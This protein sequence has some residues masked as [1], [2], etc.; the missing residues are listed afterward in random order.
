MANK[1][2]RF[3]NVDIAFHERLRRGYLELAQK[4]PE[5]FIVINAGGTIEEVTA[6]IIR[7]YEERLSA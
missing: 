6:E 2:L 5:R 3:E 1:E 4:E 7:K